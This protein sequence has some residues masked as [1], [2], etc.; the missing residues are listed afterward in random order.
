MVKVFTGLPPTKECS[1]MEDIPR[2]YHPH[3]YK[4]S[5]SNL[6]E[7]QAGLFNPHFWPPHAL[8]DIKSVWDGCKSF[9][10]FTESSI[11]STLLP[12]KLTHLPHSSPPDKRVRTLPSLQRGWMLPWAARGKVQQVEGGDPSLPSALLRLHLQ[13][14]ARSPLQFAT[15]HVYQTNPP[16]VSATDSWHL[17]RALINISTFSLHWQK[18]SSRLSQ[19]KCILH[20][21]KGRTD[22]HT[23]GLI[24][25][26]LTKKIKT[27][28]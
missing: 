25:P 20:S 6:M 16:A 21:F 28:I 1:T 8:L 3:P 19:S 24:L 9:R 22:I 13:G 4:N 2:S 17:S 23:L 11:P 10:Y 5:Q 18:H 7:E 26:W 12:C 14:C 27:S 15:F